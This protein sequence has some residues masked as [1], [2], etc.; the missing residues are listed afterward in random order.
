MNKLYLLY[1]PLLALL[2][3]GCTY[4]QKIRDGRTAFERKQFSVAIPML[5]K[6]FNKEKSRVEKGKIAFLLGESYKNLTQNDYAIEWYKNAYDNQYGI[7]ALEEYAFTLKRNQ[8]YAE[9]MAAFKELGIEIGSPYEYRR[10]I[11]ACEIAIGWQDTP[12]EEFSVKL[13]EFN[14]R[15][16]DYSPS[17]YKNNQLVFTSDRMAS[18]GEDIY[19]W[20]GNEYSDLFVVGINSNEVESFSQQINSTFNEGTATFNKTF[21]EVYFTRCFGGKGNDQY[22]KL[23]MSKANGNFWSPPK[24]LEF[25]ENN[26]NYGHPSLSNDGNTLYFSS[27]H[28]EGWGGFDIYASQR[29]LDGWDI[30]KLLSR[31][32]NTPGDEKFP[33]VIADTLYFASDFHT[34]MGG[35]D[36]FKTYKLTNG[37]WA[38]VQNLKPPINSGGDD[39]GL[40]IHEA[41][42]KNAE[43]IQSGYFTST[44]YDGAGSDD[45]YVF[46]QRTPPPPSPEEIAEEPK[47]IIYKMTLEGYVVEKIYEDPGDPNSKVLGRKPLADSKVNIKINGAEDKNI[48]LGEDGFFTFELD[49]NTVYD[50]IA[51]KDNFLNNSETFSTEG[52]GKDP[53]NPVQKFEVEILLDKIFRN[54]EI[55]L[56]NIYYDFDKW[57]IR[58]DAMPTL[59]DLAQNLLLNPEIRI[60]LASHTDCRGNARYNEDLS[61]KRA[62]SAV[63][64]LISKGIESDRLTAKGFGEAVLEINCPC[65]RCSEE[66]HQ[67]NRRTTFTILE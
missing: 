55:R 52:I 14:S 11:S 65:S 26:V 3:N 42:S 15:H 18:T 22:C 32:I 6:E 40:I 7:E 46:E 51:S 61:Q 1:I 62:Q 33:Y 47:E 24:I 28:S 54:K 23:M 10:E 57:D 63:D 49:Q 53:N 44:R 30:P 34:G 2:I 13:A 58:E 27:N 4:T 21:T 31:S 16:A 35:L 19:N 59:N 38:P 25:V 5:K 48:T 60:Q 43:I 45:I 29:T 56:E 50:F 37:Y 64:Y 17:I 66:E 36:I 20:T 8:Q 9:A 12:S 67:R 41:A 39:F